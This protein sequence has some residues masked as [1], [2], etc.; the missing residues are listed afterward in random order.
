MKNGNS[1]H[2]RSKV[3]IYEIITLAILYSR[4]AIPSRLH[5]VL[6]VSHRFEFVYERRKFLRGHL[7]LPPSR[8]NFKSSFSTAAVVVVAAVVSTFNSL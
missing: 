5:K 4:K 6:V 3:T 2:S 1:F 8:H 7:L